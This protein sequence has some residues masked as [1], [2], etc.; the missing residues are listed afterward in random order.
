MSPRGAQ[1]T[2]GLQRKFSA[3][4]GWRRAGRLRSAQAY[5]AAMR[6]RVD[7]GLSRLVASLSCKWDV[8]RRWSEIEQAVEATFREDFETDSAV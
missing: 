5:E 2:S 4:N 7:R 1:T 3:E 8:G 6:A